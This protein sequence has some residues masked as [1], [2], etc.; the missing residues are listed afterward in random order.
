M[1][2]AM[3]GSVLR[4]VATTGQIRNTNL[5]MVYSVNF[6]AKYEVFCGLLYIGGPTDVRLFFNYFP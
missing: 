5:V 1:L 3:S 2:L 4:H 6:F